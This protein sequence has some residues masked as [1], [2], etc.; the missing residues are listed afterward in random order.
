M[1]ENRT[2]YRVLVGSPDTKIDLKDRDLGGRIILKRILKGWEG[3][4]CTIFMW[5][6][7]G[8]VVGFVNTVMNLRFP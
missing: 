3:R 6:R 7:V 2:A 5:P 8:E 1:R 4:P